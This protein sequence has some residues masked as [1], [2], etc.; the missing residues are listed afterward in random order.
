MFSRFRRQQEENEFKVSRNVFGYRPWAED[1]SRRQWTWPIASYLLRWKHLFPKVLHSGRHIMLLPLEK[2]REVDKKHL[3]SMYDHIDRFM[4]AE[5]GIVYIVVDTRKSIGDA[6]IM[7][8]QANDDVEL[9]NGT[10]LRVNKVL[11]E[12]WRKVYAISCVKYKR[13]K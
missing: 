4:D 13:M 11:R 2:S 9:N 8:I 10:V 5:D 7:G 3:Q 12:K 6:Y 1:V